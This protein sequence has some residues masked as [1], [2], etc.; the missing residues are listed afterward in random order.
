MSKTPLPKSFCHYAFG[1]LVLDASGST[2]PC[3][4]YTSENDPSLIFSN[5]LVD[6]LENAWHS[7]GLQELRQQFLD[8]KY[9]AGCKNCWDKEASGMKSQRQQY[10][11]RIK[12]LPEFVEDVVVSE[13]KT[14][15]LKLSH[16][17]NLK[18]RM[19][20]KQSSSQIF[21]EDQKEGRISEH[22]LEILKF[23]ES[24]KISKNELNRQT[25]LNWI[26][27]LKYLDIHGGEPTF[28]PENR[29]VEELIIESG[30]AENISIVMNTNLTVFNKEL[31]DRWKKFK[32]VT[33]CFSIDD[34][35]PRI[36]YARHGT[37]WNVLVKNLEMFIA[38]KTENMDICI[39][40]TVNNY[41]VWYLPE[42]LFWIED[43]FPTL[44][45]SFGIVTQ[46][47]ELSILSI[48]RD[49][50]LKIVERYRKALAMKKI[51]GHAQSTYN[52]NQLDNIINTLSSETYYDRM[53]P[54]GFF[55]F[56]QR[57]DNI[58]NESFKT[59][60]PEWF[61]EIVSSSSKP[62]SP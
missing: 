27:T 51:P 17:C 24:N 55:R 43:N 44:G 50:R 9:P 48:Q 32:R 25:F 59:V 12:D 45:I 39:F 10:D 5:Y 4:Q 8:G 58:R 53:W 54:L 52:R 41:N 35:G 21:S 11:Y 61:M 23:L 38:N 7:P 2:R 33:V 37:R 13:P 26:P 14:L 3:C 57:L 29:E 18:C 49:L 1:N 16:L 56:N 34:I 47:S 30:H 19:C 6:G 15:D 22:D 46:P 31:P 28:A 20:D 62:S 60:F 42:L 36:E 40:S